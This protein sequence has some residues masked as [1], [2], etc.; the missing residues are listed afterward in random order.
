MSQDSIMRSL[1]MPNDFAWIKFYSEFA[2]KMLR[3]KNDRKPLVDKSYE[4][5]SSYGFTGLTDKF[6]AGSR[7]PIRD[8]DPFSTMSLFNR[9]LKP[10]NRHD[11]ASE[12]GKFLGVSTPAPDDFSGIPVT[13][14]KNSLFFPYA[15]ERA[16]DHI[17]ALWRLF[18]SAL[19]FANDEG[20]S[21][22][23]MF[24]ESL[25][26]AIGPHSSVGKLTIGLYWIRPYIFLPLDGSTRKFLEEKSVSVPKS[27]RAEE[28]LDTREK[29]RSLLG[30]HSFPELSR[31]AYNYY[32]GWNYDPD[33]IK[34]RHDPPKP[35]SQVPYSIKD[36]VSDGC[37]V[38]E[39]ELEKMAKQLDRKMNLILQGPTGTGKTWLAKKLAFALIGSEDES[40]L[41]HIQFHSNWSYADFVR[42]YR[43]NREGKLE[44]VDGP[45]FEFAK[46]AKKDEDGKYVCVIEEINRGNL[47][48][49]FGEFL[50]LLEKDKRG[51]ELPSTTHSDTDAPKEKVF[52]PEN[53]YVIGTMNLADKSLATIDV[54]L[55]RRFAFANLEPAFNDAWKKHCH[56][57]GIKD[58]NFLNE[59][60][61]RIGELNDKIRKD[62]DLGDQYC[63]G[64]SFFTPH[65]A[66]SDHLAWYNDIV[67]FEAEPLLDEYLFDRIRGTD[68]DKMNLE[69][70]KKHLKI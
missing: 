22:R 23:D 49:I 36:I 40:H 27:L 37:F 5:Y 41:L 29:I 59:L 46:K 66:V 51:I 45:F 19:A 63:I 55:R 3:H 24:A 10:E 42:G 70:A 68:T 17:D 53:L 44:P 35:N 11:I 30:S 20:V 12:L 58:D 18:V 50:T 39:S 54:A 21:L 16:P 52:L 61:K 64:H 14:N 67:E 2:D 57:K 65:E 43:P 25:N 69:S 38:K 28:Y 32:K 8:I 60:A 34:P 15:Y 9:G 6:E 1:I 48:S 31:A 4:I 33:I 13:Y 7:G 26:S 62:P 56:D 47:S